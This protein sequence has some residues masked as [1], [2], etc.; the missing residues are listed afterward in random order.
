MALD[1]LAGML[2][3]DWN[4][5]IWKE[6][7][8]YLATAMI[9]AYDKSKQLHNNNGIG[10]SEGYNGIHL[11]LR[12]DNLLA[13]CAAVMGGFCSP[14]TMTTIPRDDDGGGGWKHQAPYHDIHRPC[15][16]QS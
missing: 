1:A 12:L 2:G 9:G 7:C 6:R 10:L 5:I 4:R 3:R 15:S 11:M 13:A 14:S 16:T 8:K